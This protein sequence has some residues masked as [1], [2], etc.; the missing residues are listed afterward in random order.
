MQEIIEFF[1][2]L[3]NSEEIIVKGG[4]ILVTLIVFAETGLFFCFWL[5]GD[6]LLFLAGV[7]CGTKTFNVEINTLVASIFAAAI[8]GNYMG[9]I[10]GVTVGGKLYQRP[11]SLFFKRKYLVS[12]REFFEKYGGKTLIIARFLPIVRTFAPVLAGM[13]HMTMGSFTIYN[14]IGGTLWVGSLVLG[15]YFL[16]V[17]YPGII[18]YVHWIII[19]FIGFTTITIIQSYL[20]IRQSHNKKQESLEV[21]Q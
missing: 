3:S 7:L 13:S 17:K 18:N 1:G 14:L 11:D 2:M 10:F 16:G 21:E 6:Y 8:L 5:P 20:K 15:G 4:L 12:T 19:G 9:Y